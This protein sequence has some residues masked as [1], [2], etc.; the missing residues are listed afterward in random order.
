MRYPKKQLSHK[1]HYLP[2]FYIKGFVNDKV[3]LFVYDKK[4]DIIQSKFPSQIFFEMEK[5]ISDYGFIKDDLLE[6]ITSNID[7]KLAPIFQNIKNSSSVTELNVDVNSF[8]VL[9]FVIDKYLK[10][11]ANQHLIE[12]LKPYILSKVANQR[13]RNFIKL[14]NHDLMTDVI[15]KQHVDF[16]LPYLEVKEFETKSLPGIN[17]YSFQITQENSLVIS[18]YPFVFRNEITGYESIKTNLVI[19]IAH[20]KLYLGVENQQKFKYLDAGKIAAF[21]MIQFQQC[22]RYVGCRD[23]KMLEILVIY[24]KAMKP[25]LNLENDKKMFFE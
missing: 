11:P 15:R 6:D 12:K 24:Y 23:R 22:V 4:Y 10:L 21:N 20:N 14:L 16:M 2:E 19:P 9:L 5:N 8:S 25:L 18:D 7:N 17:Y 1:H 3:K 13:S